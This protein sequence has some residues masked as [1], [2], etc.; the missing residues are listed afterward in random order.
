[1]HEL[2][3]AFQF[4]FHHAGYC[5]GSRAKGALDLARAEIE[6]YSHTPT[7][8]SLTASWHG[9]DA[10][11][12]SWGDHEFW[13][14]GA[15][16]GDCPGH[17]T[18]YC[19]VTYFNPKTRRVE[20]L[21]GVGGVIDPDHNYQRVIEAELFAEALAILDQRYADSMTNHATQAAIGE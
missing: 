9:D 21:A 6:A 14:A 17:E 10:G 18:L 5:V 8:G 4:F 19:Q 13:C 7:Y 2:R 20:T 3:K 11:S 1:M 15:R 12:D 16:R